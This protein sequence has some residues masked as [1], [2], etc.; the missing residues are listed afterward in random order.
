MKQQAFEQQYGPLW[1]AVEFTLAEKNGLQQ[2]FPRQ[3]RDLCHHL[4]LAKHRRYS[5]Q[6]V[7]RLNDL[8]IQAHHRFYQHNRRFNYQWIDFLVFSFPQAIRRNAAYV[9]VALGLFVIP[10][11]VMGIGCFAN[12]EL[13][14]SVSAS[15]QVRSYEAMYDPENRKIGRER[16]AETDLA[17]FGFYIKNNIGVSFRTFAG[18]I[19]FG[20]GSIFFLVFNGL[21]IGSVAGHLTQLQYTSTFYPFVVGHGAFELT[22]IVFSGAAG[23]KLG[24]ALVAPGPL[25]RLD[26]LRNAGRDAMS[27]IY[28]ST[29]MLVIAA[30]LEAFWS[31]STT[32]GPPVKYAVGGV[33][34]LLVLIYFL[35]VGRKTAGAGY[36]PQ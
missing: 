27:I 32:I 29:L 4:A 9:G 2:E 12:D 7:D 15:E 23:L 35:F 30:F 28:G 26:A 17:M 3:F 5:P 21:A 10:L 34:W 16:D 25:T 14:Y 31:S 22:A 20:L 13:I 33:L 11:L 8:V 24:H 19:L 36:G 1:D 18:G 6:L